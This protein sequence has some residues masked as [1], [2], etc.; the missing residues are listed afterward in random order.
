[1]TTRHYD[2]KDLDEIIANI[3]IKKVKSVLKHSDTL[4]TDAQY[5]F[6]NS[7]GKGQLNIVSYLVATD[8]V[9]LQGKDEIGEMGICRASE[10]GEFF[11]VSYLS[12]F[13]ELSRVIRPVKMMKC[14][15]AGG[16]LDIVS[17]LCAKVIVPEDYQESIIAE[18][19]K[20][21]KDEI[22]AHLEKAWELQRPKAIVKRTVTGE[23]MRTAVDEKDIE[24]IKTS[25][26]ES[27]ASKACA[28]LCFVYA[29]RTGNVFV[30]SYFIEEYCNQTETCCDAFREAVKAVN[31]AVV[32]VMLFKFERGHLDEYT[33]LDCVAKTGNIKMLSLFAAAGVDVAS[34][35]EFLIAIAKE[36]KHV[37]FEKHVRETYCP[38][39]STA[40]DLAGS[41]RKIVREAIN[42]ERA[43]VK[44]QHLSADNGA[45]E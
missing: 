29:A 41:L 25:I 16:N 40:N 15:V 12:A 1:M 5:L 45:N 4:P 8:S 39:K 36:H 32:A 9:I 42:E 21:G 7:C 18:A 2:M 17:L 11:V 6:V 13:V 3:D 37:E 28:E 10:N 19:R 27:H 22:A 23:E 26:A 24:R 31:F 34:K 14:A 33:A 30:T 20:L 35:A 44:R 43:E 38:D